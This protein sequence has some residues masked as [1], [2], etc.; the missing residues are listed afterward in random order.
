VKASDTT[1]SPEEQRRTD[2]QAAAVTAGRIAQQ[3]VML[4]GPLEA[5]EVWRYTEQVPEGNPRRLYQLGW[6]ELGKVNTFLWG[7]LDLLTGD[8]K[9]SQ[10]LYDWIENDMVITADERHADM[11]LNVMRVR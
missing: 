5:A 11:A 9:S 4:R 2:R 6:D 10:E 8:R 7:L 1:I 3:L